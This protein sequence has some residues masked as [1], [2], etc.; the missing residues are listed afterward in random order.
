MAAERL[1]KHRRKHRRSGRLFTAIEALLYDSKKSVAFRKALGR[2][3]AIQ[4][5]RKKNFV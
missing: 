2:W 1:L 3:D 5:P 4:V